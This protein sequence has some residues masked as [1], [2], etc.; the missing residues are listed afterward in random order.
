MPEKDL[1]GPGSYEPPVGWPKP[2]ILHHDWCLLKTHHALRMQCVPQQV[3]LSESTSLSLWE[4]LCIY[5]K[6]CIIL[7]FAFCWFTYAV[8]CCCYVT[9]FQDISGICSWFR[10]KTPRF[11]F[12]FDKI[13]ARRTLSRRVQQASNWDVNC[14][15][16]QFKSYVWSHGTSRHKHRRKRQQTQEKTMASRYIKMHRRIKLYNHY[17]RKHCRRIQLKA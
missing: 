13:A 8:A 1:P 5:C 12:V 10:S 6:S 17:F 11:S 7:H 15:P 3:E 4:T 14:C 2:M 16:P 9:W